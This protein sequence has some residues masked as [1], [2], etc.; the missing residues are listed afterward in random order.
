[1][2]NVAGAEDGVGVGVSGSE[3]AGRPLEAADIQNMVGAVAD[4]VDLTERAWKE[5]FNLMDS[6]VS[7][8]S[9]GERELV[10]LITELGPH[11]YCLAESLDI[12]QG[13]VRRGPVVTL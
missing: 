11:L 8:W 4:M 10:R 13:S 9:P 5:V 12:D 2:P 1:M 6:Q 3:S 7:A